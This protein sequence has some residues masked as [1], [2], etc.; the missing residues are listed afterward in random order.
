MFGMLLAQPERTGI[1]THQSVLDML[2]GTVGTV[3]HALKAGGR[4]K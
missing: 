1:D 3:A 2:Q 4:R